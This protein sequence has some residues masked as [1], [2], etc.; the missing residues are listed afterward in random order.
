MNSSIS[1][2]VQNRQSLKCPSE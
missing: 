2:K 1:I